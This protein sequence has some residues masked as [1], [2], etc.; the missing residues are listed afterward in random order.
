APKEEK[1]KNPK[2]HNS[3]TPLKYTMSRR[4]ATLDINSNEHRTLESSGTGTVQ[5]GATISPTPDQTRG[6]ATNSK[7]RPYDQRRQ[8]GNASDIP[9]TALLKKPDTNRLG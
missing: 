4:G 2:A 1:E 7:L 5:G 6:H 9:P 8:P 3:G